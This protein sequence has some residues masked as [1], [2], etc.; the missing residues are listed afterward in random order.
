[1]ET[2]TLLH[3]PGKLPEQSG[4]FAP[5]QF[6]YSEKSTEENHSKVT[7]F[8]RDELITQGSALQFGLSERY[9]QIHIA[10][11]LLSLQSLVEL[12]ANQTS[13]P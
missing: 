10:N 6:A 1:M 13:G 3:E 12:P 9:S 2:T 8:Y 7:M 4:F 11:K 5:K